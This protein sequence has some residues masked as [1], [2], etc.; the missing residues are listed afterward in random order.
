MSAAVFPKKTIRDVPIDGRTVLL[1]V[2]YNLPLDEQGMIQDDYRIRMTLPT[3]NY[4]RERGCKLIVCSHLGR[5]KGDADPKLSLRLVAMRLSEL[6]G[7]EVPFVP[8]AVG[9]Q[10]K[11]TAKSLPPAGVMMIE[12]LRFFPGEKAN[13]PEFAKALAE[14]AE[15]LVQE[16]F[17]VAHRSDASLVGVAQELPA[18]AGFLL[19]REVSTISSAMNNPKKPVAAIVG[20][21][22][23]ESK[24]GVIEQFLKIANYL[25]IGG[26][27]ANTF[28]KAMGYKIGKSIHDDNEVDTAKELL[29]LADRAEIQLLLPLED[30]AVSNDVSDIAERRDVPT[31]HVDKNDFI[32]DIGHKSTEHVIQTISHAGTVIWSGPLGMTE[33]ESFRYGSEMVARFIADH[34]I[35]SII[36]GG[37]TAEFI[38]SLGL[39][40]DFTHV[41]TGGGASLELMAGHSLPGVEALLDR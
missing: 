24:I 19:E 32:L 33:L 8:A 20:G 15:Y 9:D 13:D 5:P 31:K 3:I 23:I 1:R 4:L 36:G 37:D 26:A 41:S 7:I 40:A 27:M 22:K 2:D 35:D 12:N 21:A 25:V 29:E 10:V 17:A 38:H 39:G 6:L 16:A 34:H 18:V 11:Q 14:P 30:V 28:L